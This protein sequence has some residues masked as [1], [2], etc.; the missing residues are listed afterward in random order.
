MCALPTTAKHQPSVY[1]V[2]ARSAARGEQQQESGGR[3]QVGRG[4][5]EATME[6]PDQRSSIGLVRVIRQTSHPTVAAAR[7]DAVLFPLGYPGLPYVLRR[8]T[9]PRNAFTTLPRAQSSPN[10]AVSHFAGASRSPDVFYERTFCG[11]WGGC[12]NGTR[13]SVGRAARNKKKASI[14]PTF[15]GHAEFSTEP[16]PRRA[17]PG[18]GSQLADG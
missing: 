12:L 18:W 1:D 9:L 16:P 13:Q 7:E 14:C 4:R 3:R 2:D 8:S 15:L 17:T 11:C 10:R 6:R 5:T